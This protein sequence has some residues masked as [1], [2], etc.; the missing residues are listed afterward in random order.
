MCI[1]TVLFILVRLQTQQKESSAK[2]LQASKNEGVSAADLLHE[3][4]SLHA[5]V[6]RL[7]ALTVHQEKII[8]GCVKESHQLG[9]TL[10]AANTRDNSATD[11]IAAL[12]EELDQVH[13][14]LQSQTSEWPERLR[15]EEARRT[16]AEA[17][18]AVLEGQ[19][20][21][22]VQHLEDHL[23]LQMV[24]AET[25]AFSP[26]D[27][28][29]IPDSPEMEVKDSPLDGELQM[30]A[31]VDAE[32]SAIV[33]QLQVQVDAAKSEAEKLAA[34]L[35]ARETEAERSRESADDAIVA[36]RTSLHSARQ[37]VTYRTAEVSSLQ[38]RITEI[39]HRVRD[40]ADAAE[41]VRHLQIGLLV[42]NF[43]S[44]VSLPSSSFLHS[45][46]LCSGQKSSHCMPT[47][48]HSSRPTTLQR[49]R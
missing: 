32:H 45:L 8:Q 17:E 12:Q 41:K 6:N 34:N 27:V 2:L 28:Y 3:V 49:P 7:T 43:G 40:R 11:T 33:A 42:V 22:T 4:E 37:E 26:E 5:E 48:V 13:R 1:L 29:T 35:A 47:A 9:V 18:C 15:E 20:A 23:Q 39:I 10:S 30:A 44:H 16:A 19:L 24:D 46:K 25:R 31:I 38:S 36:L 21:A 14:D